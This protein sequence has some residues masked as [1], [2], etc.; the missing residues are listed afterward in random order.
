[1]TENPDALAAVQ[2]LGYSQMPVVVVNDSWHWSGLKYTE[3]EKLA[4]L[5]D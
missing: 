4:K 1:M 5:S 3:I 2:A